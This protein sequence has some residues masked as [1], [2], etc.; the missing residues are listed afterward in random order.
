MRIIETVPQCSNC[1]NPI[2]ILD[3]VKLYTINSLKNA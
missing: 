2:G 3:I 1:L